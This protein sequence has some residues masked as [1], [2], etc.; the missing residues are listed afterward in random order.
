MKRSCGETGMTRVAGEDL[1][2]H[3]AG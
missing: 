1:L 3:P 2:A